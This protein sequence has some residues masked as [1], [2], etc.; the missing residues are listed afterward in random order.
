MSDQSD[1][2]DLSDTSDTSDRSDESEPAAGPPGQSMK[3]FPE[4][5]VAQTALAG[6]ERNEH[7]AGAGGA[8]R[9]V[10]IMTRRVAAFAS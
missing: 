1:L 10:S 4:S 5:A 3:G 2:S 6:P 7:V 9:R 8:L